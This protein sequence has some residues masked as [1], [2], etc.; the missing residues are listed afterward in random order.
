MKSAI[1]AICI[2]GGVLLGSCTCSK[3]QV[4]A[5]VPNDP[6]KS[7]PDATT[8]NSGTSVRERLVSSEFNRS[9]PLGTNI[10]PIVD[11]STNMPFVDQFKSSRPWISGKGWDVWN[12]KRALDLDES[13]WVRSLK[14]DQLARTL[15]LT[16]GRHMGGRYLLL[17]DG[18]GEIE[19]DHTVKVLESESRPGRIV[20]QLEENAQIGLAISQ[21]NPENPL[22]NIRVLPPGGSCEAS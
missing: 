15:I 7:A 12:D 8:A 17:H 19:F 11:W 2:A 6:P 20:L 13:G 21:T 9:S 14:P 18:E 3:H 5:S 1:F 10:A 22:R 4:P 16:G